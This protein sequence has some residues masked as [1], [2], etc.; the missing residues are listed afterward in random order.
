MEAKVIAEVE[1]RAH[2]H[3]QSNHCVIR[4]EIQDLF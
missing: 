1:V 4:T 3:D 2:T